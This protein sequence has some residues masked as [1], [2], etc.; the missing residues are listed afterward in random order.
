M[1]IRRQNKLLQER[2]SIPF[3]HISVT[4]DL[5]VKLWDVPSGRKFRLERVLYNNVTGLAQDGTNFFD[6]QILKGATVM[7]NHSTE[8]G[9]E[10]TLTA[11]TPVELVLSATDANLVADGGDVISLFLEEGGA[12]TLPAGVFVLEG[13]LL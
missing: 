5:T 8:T 3:D 9:Q 4:A 7:A 10:G 1:A 12:A 2:I 11:D 6:I 13:R